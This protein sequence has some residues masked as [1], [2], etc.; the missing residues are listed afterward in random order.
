VVFGFI[1]SFIIMW[2]AATPGFSCRH[3]WLLGVFIAWLFSAFFTFFTWCILPRF[4]P[5]DL[6]ERY[7]FSNVHWWVVLI[8]DFSIGLPSIAMIF[9]ST[10][11]LFNSCYCW[12]V[13]LTLHEMA[14]FPLNTDPG[15]VAR[16]KGIYP[17]A[18]GICLALELGLV[19]AVVHFW[20]RGLAVMRW[21]EGH[22]RQEWLNTL[23]NLELRARRENMF[24]FWNPV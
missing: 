5:K 8:K 14:S 10:A 4:L 6:R 9:L 21:G 20:R 19:W 7:K 17:A 16:N 3:L 24:L 22:K 1:A 11:G 2:E 12:S 15:Y 13:T 18:V 23:G